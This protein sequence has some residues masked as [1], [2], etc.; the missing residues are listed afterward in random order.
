MAQLP[1]GAEGAAAGVLVWSF[2]CLLANIL[3]QWLLWTGH[4]RRSCQSLHL[5]FFFQK[6]QC[7]EINSRIECML[8]QRI[9]VFIV[10]CVAL[11]ATTS[12]IIQQIYDIV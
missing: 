5:M 9:D 11:L 2:T 8:T 6:P 3:L 7:Q 4:E 1:A 10:A 12:S